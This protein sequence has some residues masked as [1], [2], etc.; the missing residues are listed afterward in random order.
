MAR[1]LRL[2]TV[3][4]GLDPRD[5]TFVAYGG[6]GPLHAA[7]LARELGVARTV[8]P[9]APAHFSAVGMLLGD[10]RADAVRTHVGPLDPVGLAAALA[11]LEDEAAA[12][13]DE[14]AGARS[15]ERFAQL[16]YVGQEHTLE[17]PLEPGEVSEDLLRRLRRDFD[18]ASDEAYAFSLP[19]AT[20]EVVAL[21]VSVA[22]SPD[23]VGWV[24]ESPVTHGAFR[25]RD[26]DFDQHGGIRRAD[27]IGRD[28]LEPGV[29]RDGPCVIEE[30]ATTVLVLPGQRVLGDELGNLVIE[31]AS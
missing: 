6:A 28:E 9:P 3:R 22:A 15:V 10:F 20:V 4:R 26:V 27:V 31:E 17:V 18:V 8:I 14:E 1:A 25:P 16:R 29:S 12:E 24:H 30:P 5:F 23:A 21:R 2:V 11:R 19:D 13:L 7:V